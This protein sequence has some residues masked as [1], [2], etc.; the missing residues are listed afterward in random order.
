MNQSELLH[1]SSSPQHMAGKYLTFSLENEEYGVGILKVKEIIGVM[2]VTPIPKT[3][4]H[5]KGVINL[6]GKVIPIIDM[7][8]KF[9]MHEA[10]VNERTCVVVVEILNNEEQS[11][12]GV[13]V[14]SVSEVINIAD[15]E[16]EDAPDFGAG[17]EADSQY[18]VGMAKTGDG[19]KILLDIDQVIT[20]E[21]IGYF[22]A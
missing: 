22:T 16:I 9:E 19:V 21:D 6:R 4:A 10:E 3:P 20:G 12:I 15:E 18:I 14:D 17:V 11:L 7:R 1:T 13:V 8:L 5:V 2:P